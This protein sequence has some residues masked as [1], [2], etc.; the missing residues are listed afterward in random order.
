MKTAVAAALAAAIFLI[1]LFLGTRAHTLKG[2]AL[3]VGLV[4]DIGGIGDKSFND[5]AA[6]GLQR[7]RTTLGV[8]AATLEPGDGDGRTQALRILASAG[9]KIVFGV[10]FIFTDDLLEVAGDYPNVRFAGIDFALRPGMQIPPNI[11]AIKFREEQGSFLA[12]A[13]AAMISET[14]VLGFVGGMDIPLI[15]KFSAGYRAGV[16]AVCPTCRVRVLFAG[17]TPGAFKDPG[18]GHEMALALFADGADIVYHAAGATGLGAIHAAKES[19]KLAIG[20]DSDQQDEAPDTIITSVVK[21]V[22]AAVL[23]SI[24]EV[25]RGGAPTGV[26]YYGLKENGVELAVNEKNRH[27]F[28]PE[29][30]AKLQELRAA[31]ERGEIE[32]PDHD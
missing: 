6:L 5:S 28:T 10:G 12:G 32:V 17:L 18:R 15:H 31:I 27:F 30:S 20:V 25:Q 29:R 4:F 13:L 14:H 21:R 23:D 11:L 2:D 3:H 7:A 1:T 8:D 22:D 16:M 24:A 26:R 9:D 19:H